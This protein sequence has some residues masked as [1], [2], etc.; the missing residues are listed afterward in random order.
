MG[1]NL[2]RRSVLAGAGVG[3]AVL[4]GGLAAERAVAA[5]R[6]DGLTASE[7]ARLARVPE[8]VRPTDRAALGRDESLKIASDAAP[9]CRLVERALLAG[10]GLESLGLDLSQPAAEFVCDPRRP[11][12]L[13]HGVERVS[14]EIIEVAWQAGEGWP[15]YRQRAPHADPVIGLRYA[16][17]PRHQ[18]VLLDDRA[19]YV[20]NP[21]S[22]GVI[23]GI[24][25]P[26]RIDVNGEDHGQHRGFYKI[27]ITGLA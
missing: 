7:R 19:V 26:L 1:R 15:V 14:Y 25:G 6:R 2:T 10:E 23:D 17:V 16:G 27:L 11:N 8:H 12:L 9:A 24:Q 20:G 4:A 22:I 21:G 3:G 13:L 18:I 5:Y